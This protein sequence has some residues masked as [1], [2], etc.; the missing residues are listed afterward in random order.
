M[1][2]GQ[3]SGI[4][5]VLSPLERIL[6]VR[7]FRWSDTLARR[8]PSAPLHQQHRRGL[9]SFAELHQFNFR[10]RSD[11]L[12]LRAAGMRGVIDSSGLAASLVFASGRRAMA[13]STPQ[14]N[15]LASRVSPPQAR[16]PFW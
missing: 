11:H 2:F 16:H 1:Q 8:P 5:A 10:K 15:E 6:L 7:S 3:S 13:I 4:D 14:V 12:H 9:G